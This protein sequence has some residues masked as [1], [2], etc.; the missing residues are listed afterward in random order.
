MYFHLNNEV[1]ILVEINNDVILYTICVLINAEYYT[2]ALRIGYTIHLYSILSIES[3]SLLCM[4]YDI[5]SKL[6]S[7]YIILFVSYT[8]YSAPSCFEKLYKSSYKFDFFI[9]KIFLVPHFP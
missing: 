4:I 3:H 2:P 9:Y 7:L 6:I 1:V 8:P 5:S